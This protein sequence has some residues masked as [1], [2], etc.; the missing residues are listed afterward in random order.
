MD[1]KSTLKSAALAL[2]PFQEEVYIGYKKCPAYAK[3]KAKLKLQQVKK[4]S[5]IDGAMGLVK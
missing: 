2:E 4:C 1:K 5:D 3:S